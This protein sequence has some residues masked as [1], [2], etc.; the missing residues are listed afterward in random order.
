M[1]SCCL[2][3]SSAGARPHTLLCRRVTLRCLQRTA[4]YSCRHPASP[5]PLC[6]FKSPL[7][8][9]SPP[10]VVCRCSACGNTQLP[11]CQLQQAAQNITQL[12]A[13][14]SGSA[15]SD[16]ASYD[17]SSS[18]SGS[19]GLSGSAVAGIAIGCAAATAAVLSAAFFVYH[20]KVTRQ[21]RQAQLTAAYEI[22]SITMAA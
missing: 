18:S 14:L 11:A 10:T 5:P 20:R 12:E 22:G 19:S 13:R 16:G 8:V 4:P 21:L 6:A 7:S 2:A 3:R 15:T 17:S 9:L 1:E